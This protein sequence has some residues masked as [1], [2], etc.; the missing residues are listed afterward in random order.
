MHVQVATYKIDEIGDAEFNEANREFASMMSAVPGLLAKVWLKSPEGNVYGGVYF[1][2]DRDAYEHF[3]GSELWA[4]VLNDDSLS[5]LES[6][7]FS[8]MDE[9]S[10]VTQPGLAILVE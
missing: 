3:I 6:H 7:D 5:D 2:R 4:S 9:L 8:V 10:R 1:W